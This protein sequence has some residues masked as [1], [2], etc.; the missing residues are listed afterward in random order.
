MVHQLDRIEEM[1]H[2]LT[3]SGKPE[4]ISRDVMQQNVVEMLYA[5]AQNH[6]IEAIK[7]C[8]TLT[9][10]GLKDAKDLICNAMVTAP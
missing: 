4:F 8:R 1:L 7:I 3:S 6:K 2:Q 9:G 5:M 10:R